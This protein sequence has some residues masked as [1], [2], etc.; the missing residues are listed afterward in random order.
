MQA[1]IAKLLSQTIGRVPKLS[2]RGVAQ[3]GEDLGY[4]SNVSAVFSVTGT[5]ELTRALQ[6]A[7]R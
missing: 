4:L 6:E 1:T 2:R 3:L 7:L 5:A